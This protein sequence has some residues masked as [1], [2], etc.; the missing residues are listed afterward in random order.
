[1]VKMNNRLQNMKNNFRK[2]SKKLRNRVGKKS[3]KIKKGI[4]NMKKKIQ[5]RMRRVNSNRRNNTRNNRR[6]N[7]RNNTRNNRRKNTRNNRRNNRRNMTGG[8]LEYSPLPCDANGATDWN[9][10]NQVGHET[11]VQYGSEGSGMATQSVDT[12]KEAAYQQK[13]LEAEVSKQLALSEARAKLTTAATTTK[14]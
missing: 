2:K 7:R 6:N 4:L 5:N 8:K 10:N 3:N 1:M 12:E 11:C 13:A 9:S 14:V